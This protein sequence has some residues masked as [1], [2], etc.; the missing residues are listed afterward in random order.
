MNIIE[1]EYDF[2][3]AL[4]DTATSTMYRRYFANR[5]N[6]YTF[7][8][9]GIVFASLKVATDVIKIIKTVQLY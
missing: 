6:D 4:L 9:Y 7:Y 3:I 8:L 1:N 5:Q 2:A